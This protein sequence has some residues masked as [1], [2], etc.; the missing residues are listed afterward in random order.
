M[1]MGT[2]REIAMFMLYLV[3]VFLLISNADGF[4]NVIDAVGSNWIRTL[5]TLQG[6]GR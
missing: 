6:K 1:F 3:L 5:R 2:I 4:S